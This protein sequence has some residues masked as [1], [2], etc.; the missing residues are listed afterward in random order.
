MSESLTKKVAGLSTLLMVALAAAACGSSV[1][2]L[3]VALQDAVKPLGIGALVV[4]QHVTRI[5][6]VA[7][8]A[9][10]MS[11]GQIALSGTAQEIKERWVNV[12]NAYLSSD[13]RST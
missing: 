11:R 5:L 3:F 9:Y 7:T 2:R 10:V 1:Q 6:K 4:K 12:Q 13:G 8:R